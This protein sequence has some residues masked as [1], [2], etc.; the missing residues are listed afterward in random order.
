MK[1][2]RLM[3]MPLVLAAVVVA[4]TTAYAQQIQVRP[5]TSRE[6][7][8]GAAANFTGTALI[9]M[10]FSATGESRAGGAQVTFTPGARTTWH[11]HP[12]GQTL[13]VTSGSGWV[14]AWNGEN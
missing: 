11:S 2:Q 10:F 3:K 13:I 5:G 8:A 14:Q 6:V 9:E 7:V 1:T 4:V 12:A